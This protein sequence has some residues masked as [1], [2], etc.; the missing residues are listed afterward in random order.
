M[1]PDHCEHCHPSPTE[2]KPPQPKGWVEKFRK[3]FSLKNNDGSLATTQFSFFRRV[4]LEI[5]KGSMK[6][7]SSKGKIVFFNKCLRCGLPPYGFLVDCCECKYPLLPSPLKKEPP[8]SSTQK[9]VEKYTFKTIQ[10]IV[11]VIDVDNVDEL[12]KDFNKFL[13][14]IAP[15]GTI[16]KLTGEK[17]QL[18]K[19]EF[20]PD[21]KGNMNIKINTDE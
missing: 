3:Q 20:V 12:A 2:Q 21:G 6:S 19:F 16:A 8:K 10:D 14:I 7:K 9:E 13:H 15:M 17:L 4:V 18:N 11:D 5:Y 1:K